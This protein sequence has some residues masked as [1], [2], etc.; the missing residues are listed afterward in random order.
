MR[1]PGTG[2][3]ESN[4]L[5]AINRNSQ[6]ETQWRSLATNALHPERGVFPKIDK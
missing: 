6:P 2:Y 5:R 4:K 3:N 1:Y